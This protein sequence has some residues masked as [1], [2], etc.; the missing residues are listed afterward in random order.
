MQ[1]Q[2][3]VR[4]SGIRSERSHAV[5]DLSPQP[6]DLSGAFGCSK[7]LQG[8][9]QR[10]LVRTQQSLVAQY[11]LIDCADDG[12]KCHPQTLERALEVRVQALLL[13]DTARGVGIAR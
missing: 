8:R 3:Q 12:L 9:R 4:D 1:V 6:H 13:E 7:H 2:E 10:G 11:R 5:A